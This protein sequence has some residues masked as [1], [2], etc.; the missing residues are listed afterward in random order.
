MT[1]VMVVVTREAL[2]GV[3]TLRESAKAMAPE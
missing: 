3:L 1:M 2:L